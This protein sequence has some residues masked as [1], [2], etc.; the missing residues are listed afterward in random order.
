M[1]VDYVGWYSI[2]H[3][4]VKWSSEKYIVLMCYTQKKIWKV[5]KL[6]KIIYTKYSI[7]FENFVTVIKIMD[8]I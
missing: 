6:Q 3:L 5:H 8:K 4:K 1:L 7:M 2:F